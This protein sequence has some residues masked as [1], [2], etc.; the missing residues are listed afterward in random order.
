MKNVSFN[1]TVNYNAVMC[2]V[3]VEKLPSQH[4]ET[5]LQFHVLMW[6][7]YRRLVQWSFTKSAYQV[8]LSLNEY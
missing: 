5:Y 7:K 1:I 2:G 8:M 3:F 6:Q 4:Q